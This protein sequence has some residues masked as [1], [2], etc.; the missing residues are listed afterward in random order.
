MDYAP[1]FAQT[2]QPFFGMGMTPTPSYSGDSDK[3]G[4][5]VGTKFFYKGIAPLTHCGFV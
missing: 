2:P 4:P 3:I 5:T 1:F